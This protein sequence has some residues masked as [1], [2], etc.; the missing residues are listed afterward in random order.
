MGIIAWIIVGAIAGW[1]AGLIVKGA[2]FGLLGNIV[3]GIVGAVVA[4]WLLPQLGI[5]LGAGMIG[6]IINGAIG[7]I[8]VL[9]I[10]SLI[11]RA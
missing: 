5:R 11:R 7:G 2:G 9:V 3:V 4:G 8:V 1:L 10:L 6:E